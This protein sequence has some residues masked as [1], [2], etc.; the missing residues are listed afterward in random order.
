LRKPALQ[1]AEVSLAAP[2]A[3]GAIISLPISRMASADLRRSLPI[4]D[5]SFFRR[6]PENARRSTKPAPRGGFLLYQLSVED[7]TVDIIKDDGQNVPLLAAES[8][9]KKP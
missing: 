2:R 4:H 5:L 7:L 3:C 1:R 8:D 9:G 6:P